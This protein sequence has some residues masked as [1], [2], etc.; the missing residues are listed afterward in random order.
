MSEKLFIIKSHYKNYGVTFRN[1][2][3]VQRKRRKQT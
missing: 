1:Y 2:G 3:D